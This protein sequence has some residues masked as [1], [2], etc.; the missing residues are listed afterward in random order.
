MKKRYI[1]FLV[2]LFALLGCGTDYILSSFYLR[3]D[4]DW[5]K[6]ASEQ[7]NLNDEQF[8]MS[9]Y[10]FNK[11]NSPVILATKDNYMLIIYEYRGSANNSLIGVNG[12]QTVNI[13]IAIS[14]NAYSFT[15]DN[16]IVG[17]EG[18]SPTKS[19]GAPV[20]FL[21]T[22]N[23]IVV[24]STT[25][26]PGYG[27]GGTADDITKL[28]YS[29]STNNGY[30][31]TD[32]V[33]I[34]TNVFKPL[35]DKGYKRFYTNPGNGL[36]LKNGALVCMVDY[37][38][39][40]SSK[41]QGAAI[42]Y[43]VNGGK[44]WQLGATME[45]IGSAS[46]KRFAR[47]VAERQDGSLLIAAVHDTSSGSDEFNN[48]GPLY[49]AFLPNLQNGGV[50]RDLQVSGLPNN[51]GGSVSV[52]RIQF[53]HNNQL[54]NG[55]VIAHTTPDRIYNH[56]SLGPQK[57]KNAL[58]I[59]ISKDEGTNWTLIKNDFGVPANKTTFRQSL[60][61]LKDGSITVVNE[62]PNALSITSTLGYDIIY[63]RFGL[64]AISGGEYSYEGL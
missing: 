9:G 28:S 15:V 59:S 60:K 33:D 57:V 30:A 51:S 53:T 14:K 38:S 47:V 3:K 18:L 24:L 43:S 48:N 25:G 42:I 16:R 56:P 32:W 44:D 37:K 45:Y 54:F 34:D 4:F 10:D 35:I 7:A 1:L 26:N 49:W 6:P 55:L 52:D 40:V 61:V 23:S 5:L 64:A 29:I 21:N 19:H 46:G 36:T 31:W 27:T 41:S 11:N 50:I 20:V 2:L 39:V 8:V 13:S 63:R 17:D 58:T 22:D 12:S 62:E